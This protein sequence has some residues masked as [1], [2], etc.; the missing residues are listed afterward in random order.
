[1]TGRDGLPD[2]D[3]LAGLVA[4]LEGL[5]AAA[6]DGTLDAP[7]SQLAGLAGAVTVLRLLTD[8]LPSG[9]SLRR[10]D[11]EGAAGALERLVGMVGDGTLAATPGLDAGLVGALATLREVLAGDLPPT[12]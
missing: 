3:R 2:R 6:E 5:L 11:L 7:R 10:A 12:P 8:G 4:E 9:R 1:M